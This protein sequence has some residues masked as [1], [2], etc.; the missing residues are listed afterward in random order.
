MVFLELNV[1]GVTG[2]RVTLAT[3]KIW[4]RTRFTFWKM[5]NAFSSRPTRSG[6]PINSTSSSRFNFRVTKPCMIA[7]WPRNQNNLKQPGMSLPSPESPAAHHFCVT[8]F[9]G[10]FTH[11]SAVHLPYGAND[12]WSLAKCVKQT[13]LGAERRL[14][15][16]ITGLCRSTTYSS[17][18]A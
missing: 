5:T 17:D 11:R 7:C 2:I 8:W 14:W 4:A 6:M 10:L 16:S 18:S 1:Q 15:Y 12:A 3:W 9:A 13:L